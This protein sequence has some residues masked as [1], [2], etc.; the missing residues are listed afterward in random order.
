MKF[1]VGLDSGYG[2][3]LVKSNSKEIIVPNF[4]EKINEEQA[5][6]LAKNINSLSEKSMLIKYENEYYTIGSF[7]VKANSK[8][9]RYT[10]NDRIGNEYHLVE[11]LSC[12]GLINNNRNFEVNLVVGLPNKLRDKKGDMV[13][14]LTK[15]WK[16]SYL[17][18]NGEIERV[19][20]IREC[21]C[22]EQCL[23]AI[24]ELSQDQ[25]EELSILSIDVGQNTG[26]ACVVSEGIPSINVTDW[27]N[28]DGIKLCYENLKSKLVKSFQS[29][30][31]IYDVYDKDLQTAIETGILKV[32]NTK[33]DIADILHEVFDEYAEYVFL[34]IEDKYSDTLSNVDYTIASGGIFCSDYFSQKL[35]NKFSKYKITFAKFENPQHSVVNGM[36]NLSNILFDDDSKDDEVNEK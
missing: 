26:D 34:E 28:F 8:L 6:D 9:K 30:F 13:N 31:N 5:E 7:A 4:I 33:I 24:Y 21:G 36:Y 18:K 23:V 22:V 12:L 2:Y 17:T 11:I 29:Q 16:F 25:I 27:A 35:A 10:T 3:C 19:I 15:K 14:W 1:N 32:K 20:D